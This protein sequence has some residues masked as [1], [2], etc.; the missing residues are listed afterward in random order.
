VVSTLLP[1]ALA[2]PL[3]IAATKLIELPFLRLRERMVPPPTPEPH[4]PVG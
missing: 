4:I 2:I 1:F 3:G